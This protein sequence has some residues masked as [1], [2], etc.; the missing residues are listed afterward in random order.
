MTKSEEQR[1]LLKYYTLFGFFVIGVVTVLL[2]QILP[3]LSARLALNDAQAGT[4]F[5][6]QFTGSLVGTLLVTRLARRYGFILTTL[7]GLLLMIAGLPV[8]NFGG[9]SLCWAAIFIYGT[10]LGLTIPAINLLTIDVTPAP[11]Q[12]SSINLVNFSWGIGAICSRP[13]VAFVSSGDSLAAVTVIL[14]LA[15]AVLAVCFLSSFRSLGDRTAMDAET[16]GGERI[17]RRPASSLFIAF[18]FFVIGIESGLGG[19]LTTYSETLG[20]G[21]QAINAT[22]VFFSFMVFGRGLAS[23]ISRRITENVMISICSITLTIGIFL[24]VVSEQAAMIGAAIAGLGTSAIFPTNM[25]RFTKIF[26][27]SAT[28]HAMPLFVSGICGAASLSWLIG[29]VSTEYGSLR[30]G[31]VV[32]VIAAAVVL[33]LQAAIIAVFR[34]EMV[35]AGRARRPEL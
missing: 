31:I 8:L 17:W 35:V 5:L 13:F 25:V 16:E 9:F 26:G 10:G 34:S 3:I 27:P 28:R 15:L 2:G 4:L 18:G 11:L 14:D 1:R 30:I 23:V 12:S 22:V 7:I 24:I 33:I 21:T 19:W 29:F 32:L 20:H 6:A